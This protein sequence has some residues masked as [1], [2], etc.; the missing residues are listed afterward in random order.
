MFTV[1]FTNFGINADYIFSFKELSLSDSKIAFICQ[2]SKKKWPYYGVGML[3]IL[4][5]RYL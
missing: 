3:R 1:E 2:F 5:F 4:L